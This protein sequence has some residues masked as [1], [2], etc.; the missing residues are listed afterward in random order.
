MGWKKGDFAQLRFEKLTSG[1]ENYRTPES[2]RA[3]EEFAVAGA[4]V[5]PGAD[6]HAARSGEIR[7]APLSACTTY[8]LSRSRCGN[9]ISYFTCA[10][11]WCW[12]SPSVRRAGIGYVIKLFL[13][14]WRRYEIEFAP[15]ES[16][17]T[18]AEEEDFSPFQI[19]WYTQ[20]ASSKNK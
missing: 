2:S 11:F 15:P 18:L 19:N 7:D 3:E 1:M 6:L 10:N 20:K 9:V 12:A 5:S 16:Q 8:L 14:L 4:R 13:L 17:I